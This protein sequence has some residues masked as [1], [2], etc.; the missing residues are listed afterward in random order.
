M[1][2][3]GW[4]AMMVNDQ[5]TPF[6]Y[7]DDSGFFVQGAER[8]QYPIHHCPWCA[9]PLPNRV[10]EGPIAPTHEYARVFENASKIQKPAE[11]YEE[12]GKPD[13]DKPFPDDRGMP[14]DLRNIEYYNISDWYTLEFYFQDPDYKRF[15]IHAK[16]IPLRTNAEP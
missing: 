9:E 15:A 16:P 12:F 7:S 6:S 1:C 14:T 13:Y 2:T 3:C 11:C 4:L 8:T 5:S 10:A